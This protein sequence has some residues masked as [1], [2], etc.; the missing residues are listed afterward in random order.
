MINLILNIGCQ[1][2]SKGHHHGW[3]ALLS[4]IL[5]LFSGL[6]APVAQ[7]NVDIL[8]N[9]ATVPANTLNAPGGTLQQYSIRVSNNGSDPS[10]NVTVAITLPTGATDAVATPPGG[11]SCDAPAGGVINC[12]LA[13]IG[14]GANQTI[15]LVARLMTVGTNTLA[16]M[17]TEV[18]DS[19]NANNTDS[20]NIEVAAG[21]DLKATLTAPTGTLAAGATLAEVPHEGAVADLRFSAARAYM[22][23]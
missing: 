5:F 17:T 1:N 3:H 7:A 10:G 2:E 19:N 8:P 14:A 21:S 4:L 15:G 6:A 22:T 12:T 18:S 9:I 23:M 13:G 16:V 11:D 20:Y